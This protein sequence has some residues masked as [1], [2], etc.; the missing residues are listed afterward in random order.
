MTFE[1]RGQAEEAKASLQVKKSFHFRVYWH[2][3][4]S[5]NFNADK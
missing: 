3:V 1:S 4:S 5:E 2:I